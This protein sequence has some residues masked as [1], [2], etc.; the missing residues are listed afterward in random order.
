MLVAVGPNRGEAGWVRTMDRKRGGGMATL[1]LG[2]AGREVRAVR[3]RLNG[4]GADPPLPADA[5]SGPRTRAAVVAFHREHGL[6]PDGIVGPL[7][8]AALEL[9]PAPQN[10]GELVP[11]PAGINPGV[12]AASQ[13]TML[14]VFGRPGDL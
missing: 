11:I 2:S 4:V 7:T 9:P 3:E 12:G 1:Q 5:E 8:R 6:E 10:L 13:A 14:R